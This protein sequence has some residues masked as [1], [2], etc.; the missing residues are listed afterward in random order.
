[1]KDSG[2]YQSSH[3]SRKGRA[4]EVNRNP[5]WDE[6]GDVEDVDIDGQT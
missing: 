4:E 6:L 5:F 3:G 1:M 2:R